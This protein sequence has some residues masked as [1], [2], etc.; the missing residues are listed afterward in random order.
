MKLCNINDV[1][2]FKEVVNRCKGRVLLKSSE[3]DVFNVKS[4]L[5]Q[6]IAIGQLLKDEGNDLELFCDEK[7]DEELFIEFFKNHSEI[8]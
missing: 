3:G 5:S 1:T 6:Y 8:R 7:E 4:T 2:D